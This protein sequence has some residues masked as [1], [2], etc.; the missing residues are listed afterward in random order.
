MP[1]VP[2]VLF[3]SQALTAANQHLDA[4]RLKSPDD[5]YQSNAASIAAPDAV[6]VKEEEIARF[7]R[8]EECRSRITFHI[9]RRF[10]SLR[11]HAA[12]ERGHE[13]YDNAVVAASCSLQLVK[14][15]Q[16]EEKEA[17]A[18]LVAVER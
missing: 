16:V 1:L 13:S 3:S 4:W 2:V 17:V 6:I 5:S 18:E 15:H 7:Q 10:H 11:R 12:V 14:R 8:C 9:A